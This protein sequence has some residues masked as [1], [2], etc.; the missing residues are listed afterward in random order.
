MIVLVSSGFRGSRLLTATDHS[1]S[2][3]G[4]GNRSQRLKA[5]ARV[6]RG[7]ARNYSAQCRE[8]ATRALES[9]HAG[10]PATSR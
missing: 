8:N 7:F 1:G 5:A 9:P 4:A 2:V 3:G 10:R 6:C